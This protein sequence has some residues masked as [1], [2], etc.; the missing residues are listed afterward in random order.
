MGIGPR[1]RGMDT[2][3]LI[4]VLIKDGKDS[5]KGGTQDSRG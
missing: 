4:K 2:G 3:S 1:S 5:R